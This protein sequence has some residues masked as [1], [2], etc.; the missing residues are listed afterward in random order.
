MTPH[1]IRL[2][3]K[4][5]APAM[6]ALLNHYITNT[7]NTFITEPHTLED[8]LAWFDEHSER[9]PVL[10]AEVEGEFVGWGALSV[11]N[12][13]GGYRHTADV[14]VYVHLEF[15]RRG[16]GR[17]LLLEL[18]TRARALGYHALLAICCTESVGS[19]ALHE[20]LGFRRVGELREVGRKF[21]RWLDV[22]YLE[23]LL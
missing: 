7:T 8:R 21:D 22:A 5:D 17:A 2:A 16:I 3:T 10:A 1:S 13:R 14:S 23:L 19:I 12:P 15:H 9:H 4:A 18:I 11:H 20:S 6:T